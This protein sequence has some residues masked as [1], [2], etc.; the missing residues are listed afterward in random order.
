MM[1]FWCFSV[2]FCVFDWMISCAFISLISLLCSVSDDSHEFVTILRLDVDKVTIERKVRIFHGHS[3]NVVGVVIVVSLQKCWH[4]WDS[5]ICCS[6]LSVLPGIDVCCI[7]HP[8]FLT[9]HER[10]W[11]WVS[12]SSCHWFTLL[13]D[14]E[15]IQVWCSHILRIQLKCRPVRN[16]FIGYSHLLV[17]PV[18][19]ILSIIHPL[20][21][22][23]HE[24]LRWWVSWSSWNRGA[25]NITRKTIHIWCIWCSQILRI[26]LKCRPVWDP[27]ISN[28]HLV[29]TPVANIL[30]IIHPLLLTSHERLRWWL[31]WRSCNWFSLL[32][33]W[34]SK[35]IWWCSTLIL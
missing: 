28:F 8:L 7:I 21:L 27:G 20:L 35:Q 16:S 17:T 34:E 25:L 19:N 23:S 18:T 3:F 33:Y 11:W 30:S 22:T 14:W 9:S 15:S 6:H 26:Q 5:C 12:W 13:I 32:I 29:F 2:I 24:R 4:V 10:L 31:G 1:V